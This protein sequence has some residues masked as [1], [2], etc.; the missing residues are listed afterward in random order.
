MVGRRSGFLLGRLRPIFRGK[1]AVSFREGPFYHLW[2]R[3]FAGSGDV[4]SFRLSHLHVENNTPPPQMN[5]KSENHTCQKG[6]SSSE[7]SFFGGSMIPCKFFWGVWIYFGASFIR[8]DPPWL[9]EVSWG[10]WNSTS[11]GPYNPTTE[12]RE[13]GRSFPHRVGNPSLPASRW[14]A[15][16][17]APKGAG[18]EQ[19]PLGED[20]FGEDML[21]DLEIS[22][23]S[24]GDLNILEIGADFVGGRSSGFDL[25][26][27]LFQPSTF[28]GT[29]LVSGYSWSYERTLPSI[30][31]RVEHGRKSLTG[32]CGDESWIMNHR[33]VVDEQNLCACWYSKHHDLLLGGWTNRFEKYAPQIGSSLQLGKKWRIFQNTT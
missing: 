23:D 33:K 24:I 26:K 30:S 2:L 5:M 20:F 1:F 22:L 10:A 17:A 8:I 31:A 18:V 19:L 16:P 11:P 12:I 15:D 27:R 14:T 21:Q 4:W 6:T 28:S 9:H 7:P 32:R 13:L 29:M 25:K 3:C